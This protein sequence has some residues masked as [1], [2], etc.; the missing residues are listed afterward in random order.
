MS[1]HEAAP[2]LRAPS[3]S[4]MRAHPSL[5]GEILDWM[6]APL[7][8]LWP[9]S[10]ALTWLAARA[11]ANHSF[12]HAQELQLRTLAQQLQLDAA[13]Y[14]APADLL[15][16]QSLADEVD[17]RYL[18]LQFSGGQ[19]EG[20]SALPQPPEEEAGNNRVQWRNL[21]FD[22][23]EVRIAALR[24]QADARR[25]VLLQ[26]AETLNKRARLANQIVRGVIL[27]QFLVLPLLL[28]LVWFALTRGLAPLTWL[29]QTMRR[30]AAGDL[31]PLRETN[32]P[33]EISPLMQAMND[34]LA[35]LDDAVQQQKRFI[36]DA[37]HQMKTPLAGMRM[38]AE[39]ALTD[40]A[41]QN[42]PEVARSLQQLAKSSEQATHLVN[43]LLALA[44]LDGP[45]RAGWQQLD[46]REL[47]VQA[48][49]DWVMQALARN[50][51][52]GLEADPAQD[53]Q[54]SAQPLLLRE[55]VN[56]LLDNALRYTPP[57]GRVT[58]RLLRQE[59][60]IVLEV[61]DN[62]PGIA[63]GERERVF[64]RF[65]RILGAPGG[66]SGLGLAIVR[67]IAHK[68]GAQISVHDANP[69]CLMRLQLPLMED[70]HAG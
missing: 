64:E 62:G 2:P 28:F 10:I 11:I 15:R 52:L 24:L 16:R 31:R 36:A 19:R 27:P 21:Q 60:S 59:Q 48:L 13:G 68:H 34:M 43:Q 1:T 69:G 14:H 5:F 55:L 41:Q 32:V 7:L 8:V 67:E 30:R 66:G 18:Q 33:E 45:T 51:D 12:D 25:S 29:Q 47:A 26:V 42:L 65:Y 63:P 22:G 20:D 9:L 37:A 35:R 44:R 54:L 40:Y 23:R 57:G 70:G 39:L 4:E 50:I 61:E 58:L 56:N 46:L 49:Q 38:Q 3:R 53:W 6:L 17:L